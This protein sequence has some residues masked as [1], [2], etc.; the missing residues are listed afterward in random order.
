MRAA[1]PLLLHI[2]P[3]FSTGGA[4]VRFT[5]IAN[6]LGGAFRH[7]IFAM[8]GRYEARTLLDSALDVRFPRVDVVKGDMRG[9]L[10]RFRAA[11]RDLRR[12][13]W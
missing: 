8:D 3:S 4:Q 11:L 2:F 12:T 6:R 1:T 10:S 5:T 13:C 7:A 9:N